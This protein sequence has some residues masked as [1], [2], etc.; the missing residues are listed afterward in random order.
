MIEYEP[1]VIRE[2]ADKLYARAATIVLAHSVAGGLSGVAVGAWAGAWTAYLDRRAGG[3]LLIIASFAVV[4]GVLVA[5]L[6]Y[7]VGSARAFAL[8]LQ[9]QQALCQLQIEENTRR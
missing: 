7:L 6:G 1:T 2:F 3:A 8:R 4:G 9:A 5:L